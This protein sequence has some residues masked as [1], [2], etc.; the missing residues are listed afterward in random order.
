MKL[1]EIISKLNQS[2]LKIIDF[3]N[4]DL[5]RVGDLTLAAALAVAVTSFTVAYYYASKLGYL[6]STT[7]ISNF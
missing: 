1:E 6:A 2:K 4:A 5:D 3:Q 7:A